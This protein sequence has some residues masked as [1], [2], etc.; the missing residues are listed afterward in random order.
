ME[1]QLFQEKIYS[2]RGHKVM[3]DF[4]LAILYMVETKRLKEAVRR[5]MQRFPTDFMYELTPVEYHSLKAA[6]C[7]LREK[8]ERHIL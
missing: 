3:L 7:V 6:N 5:N 1:L 2:V 4:D 8:R